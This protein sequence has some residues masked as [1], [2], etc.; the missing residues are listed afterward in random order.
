MCFRLAAAMVAGS[1]GG[2]TRVEAMVAVPIHWKCTAAQ[3][4][5]IVFRIFSL[6]FCSLGYQR[7]FSQSR[8]VSECGQCSKNFIFGCVDVF[9]LLWVMQPCQSNSKFGSISVTRLAASLM[10]CNMFDSL[11]NPLRNCSIIGPISPTI[12]RTVSFGNRVVQWT[13]LLDM[14]HA[15]LSVT[16]VS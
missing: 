1:V 7:L 8:G 5:V 9:G 10:P 4:D 14:V 6:R 12:S 13:N 16:Q 11:P 2:C 3:I 15:P